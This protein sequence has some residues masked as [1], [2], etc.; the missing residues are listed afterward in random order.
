[1][2]TG[3]LVPE[4]ELF[5]HQVADTFSS[6][7]QSDRSWTEKLWATAAARDGSLQVAFGLG[8]Y[9]NR[10]VMDAYAG[11]SRGVEQWTVR[12]SRE[13]GRDG[14]TVVGPLSYEVSRPL[15][16]VRFALAANDAA[17][18]SFE[19]T[20]TGA[21]PPGLE[22]RELKRSWDG[23][24][25]DSDIVRFHHTGTAS[26]WVDLD[27]VRT[28]ISDAT[29][30]AARD[31]SWGVRYMIGTPPADLPRAP[32][33]EGGGSLMVWAPV[34]CERPDGSR[35]AL[36]VY[37]LSDTGPG[38]GRTEFQGGVEH[39]D[40]TREPFA[41]LRP[42]L[43]FDPAN[44]RL[45]G[46]LLHAT[47]A[48]GTSRELRVTAPTGT[49][50][51]LGPALYFGW[52]GRWHGQHRGPLRLDGEHLGDCADPETARRV[53]QLRDCV[54]RVEDPVG[55]GE[56]VGF[57]QTIAVGDHPAVDVPAAGSFV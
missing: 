33:A 37:Y 14:A 52:D 26:G 9:P 24:R 57:M 38:R 35:Y 21:V 20:F 45:R 50:F 29:W 15:D 22:Q 10:G 11:V 49:G 39:P 4:D 44:R 6:V 25:I 43:R 55:G 27:G 40:G 42:E 3:F 16:T 46:G 30:V 32:R 7:G 13:L 28:V 53:H 31:R 17:P 34:L 2:S 54:V 48:D 5:V 12:A 56:G 8:S 36:H 18:V 47:M 23:R 1:M 19:W 41:G 51:H